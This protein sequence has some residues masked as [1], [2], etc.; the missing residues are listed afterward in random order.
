MEPR[1]RHWKASRRTIFVKSSEKRPTPHATGRSNCPMHDLKQGVTV[2][3]GGAGLI[4]SAVI[5][6]INNQN[7]DNV[8]LIDVW[9]ND[10]LKKRNLEYLGFRRNLG[11]DEF[12]ELI[13]RNDRELT[14]VR[15]VIHQ[16][17]AP[18]RLRLT[19]TICETTISLHERTLRM[20]LGNGVRFVYASSAATYG[21]GTRH[22]RPGRGSREVPASSIF[23]VGPSTSSISWPA[24]S[25]WFDSITGLKY[26]NAYGPNEEHKGNSAGRKQGL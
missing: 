23:T 17:P 13:R 2:V 12:R 16:E 5:W 25:G 10:S 4:G 3:T 21:D 18:V 9:E 7:S 24:T 15:T 22:G 8:W 11:V 1:R 20:V 14:D 19:K 6:G 26:F